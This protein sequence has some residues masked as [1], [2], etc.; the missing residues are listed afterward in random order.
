VTFSSEKTGDGGAAGLLPPVALLSTLCKYAAME[1]L[2]ERFVEKSHLGGL[3][4]SEFLAL[5][6]EHVATAPEWSSTCQSKSGRRLFAEN[7]MDIFRQMD[8]R[9]DGRVSWDDYSSVRT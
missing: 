5:L 6:R 2:R 4:T 1:T 8:V 3:D 9:G 7:C